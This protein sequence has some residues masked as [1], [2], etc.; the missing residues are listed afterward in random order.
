MRQTGMSW[1]RIARELD[2]PLGT[3]H[4]LCAVGTENLRKDATA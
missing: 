3:L 1:R 2:V 4:R